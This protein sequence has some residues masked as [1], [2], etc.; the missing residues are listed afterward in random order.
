[1]ASLLPGFEYDIFISYRQK[2]NKGDRWVSDF[3]DAL[4]IELESTFK[5]EISVYFD[6]NPHDGL[7]DTHDV[8]ASLKEKLKCLVFI[9]V[10]SRTYCDPKSFAWQNEFKA[11]VEQASNDQFGLKIKLQNSNVASRVLPVRIHELDS[12]DIQ[13]CES[14]LGG[15]LRGVEFVFKSAGINR[16]LRANEDYPQ[17][18]LNKTYYRDQINKLAN[19]I[20]E[21]IE[22]LKENRTVTVADSALKEEQKL[23]S[24]KAEGVVN[25]IDKILIR[26]KFRKIPLI[27]ILIFLSLFAVITIYRTT[28]NRLTKKT[29]ALILRDNEYDDSILNENGNILM[30]VIMMKLRKVKSIKII[31][32][33][34]LDP[35]MNKTIDLNKIGRELNVKYLITGKS[36]R[37]ANE[38]RIWIELI[39]GKDN[40]Q[41]LYQKYSLDKN[42]IITI[43]NQVVW[44]IASELN[45]SLSSE[46]RYAI[47]MTPTRND[48]AY[49][50]L[51]AANSISND[52]S[53]YFQLGNKL[54]DSISFVSAIQTYDKAIKNDS[55]FALAYACRAIARSWSFGIIHTDSSQIVKCKTDIDKALRLD[56]DLPEAQIALGFYYYYCKTD[57]ENALRYFTVAAEKDPDNYEPM[58]YMAIVYRRMGNWEES[59]S[60]MNKVIKLNPKEALFLTNIGL[61]Y[62]YFHKYDSALYFHQ[63][64]I[65]NLPGWSAPY[66][67][68]A[69][70]HIYKNGD[71]ANAR[72]VIERGILNT[73][74]NFL[75]LRIQFSI[76]EGKYD[77]ALKLA[78]LF[79]QEGSHVGYLYSA[80]IYSCL[81]NYQGAGKYYD[82]ALV[83]FN[84]D[85]TNNPGNPFNHI[86][87]GVAHAGMGN[88]EKAINEGKAAV[89][90]ALKN[91]MYEL[92]IEYYLAQIYTMLGDFKNALE[93]IDK[94]LNSPSYFSEEILKLDPVWRPLASQ[95]EFK[96]IINRS[97][98]NNNK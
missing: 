77:E 68:K 33:S 6:I 23:S 40:Q 90:L 37:E 7:L 74:D 18:N 34:S 94:E 81:N 83:A 10:I 49:R 88:K 53:L 78:K 62:F 35:Y 36:G 19:A 52:A 29:I 2:D 32:K 85:I 73:P 87:A 97:L 96:S 42:Q 14:L 30:D 26:Q 93:I 21:I 86:F 24:G 11:F 28:G 67:N 4:K 50:N 25:K 98:I 22:S 48:E 59:Q 55:L 46:E 54:L 17:N 43:S 70:T 65:D 16:P 45:I 84:R 79:V 92:E 51:L 76:Y 71:F 20:E 63:K 64:A 72:I 80:R 3:V 69:E 41:L 56:K 60:I 95:P 82:S 38:T 66:N 91:D 89:D 5:E 12:D 75:E 15:V 9:P 44:D 47:E 61:S 13:M 39:K 27:L 58:F 31:A 8:D 1:M 57:Y